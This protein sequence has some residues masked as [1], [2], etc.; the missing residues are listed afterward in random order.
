VLFQDPYGSAGVANPFPAQYATNA[1]SANANFPQ[2]VSLSN[3]LPRNMKIPLITTWN[4]ALERQLAND[5]Q[6]RVAYV[7]NKGTYMG[8]SDFYQNARELNPA[9]YIPGASTTSNTQARRLNPSLGSITQ[10]PNEHNS[11]YNALQVAL[12]KRF[13][14]GFTLLANYT[15]S[16]TIDDFG[17]ANPYDREFNHGISNDDIPQLF[18]LA[19]VYQFPKAPVSGFVDRVVNGWELTAN[20][21]WQGGFPLTITSGVDNS[22]SGIGRDRADFLGGAAQL[23][24]G[25]SHAQMIA[26]WF[27]TSKFTVN[28]LGTFG[29]S[30][31]NILRGPHLFNTDLSLLKNVKMYERVSMQLRFE[32]F[33]AFNNVNFNNPATTVSNTASFGRLTSAGDPRILQAAAKIIF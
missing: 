31:K 2:P 12:N 8:P 4:I 19:G 15:W 9:V 29:N 1:P 28:A 32:F 18:K 16:K 14:H 5:M 26:Q 20:A 30:G 24:S 11:H 23:D 6:L 7:G 27:D 17:W 33:N 3:T 22:L 10:I 21:L 25:R 13:S